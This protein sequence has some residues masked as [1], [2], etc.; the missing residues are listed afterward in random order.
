[1]A[2]GDGVGGEQTAVEDGV[3]EVENEVNLAAALGEGV[4]TGRSVYTM[5]TLYI[6]MC[7]CC[8]N[9]MG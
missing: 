3:E 2:R 8:V 1:M 5:N 9:M 4:S 6:C 7:T